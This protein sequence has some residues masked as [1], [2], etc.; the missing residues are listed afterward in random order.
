MDKALPPGSYYNFCSHFFQ[1]KKKTFISDRLAL[2]KNKSLA[3][4]L[5]SR[6]PV[7][8]YRTDAYMYHFPKHILGFR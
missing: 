8:G 7:P 1:E 3:D 4:Y 5:I 2:T 6:I